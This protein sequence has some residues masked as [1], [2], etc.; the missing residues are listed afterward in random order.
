MTLRTLL[1][2]AL[3][4]AMPCSL[5]ADP[6]P[7]DE[8]VLSWDDG[9]P[10]THIA[11]ETDDRAAVGFQAPSVSSRLVG[12]QFYACDDGA[13]NPIHPMLPTTAPFLFQVWRVYSSSQVRPGDLV[14]PGYV[15]FPDWYSYPEDQWLDIVLPNPIDVGDTET[16]PEGWFFIGLKWM[17][18]GNPWLGVD[19]DLPHHDVGWKHEVL[20]WIPVEEG[21][22]LLRAVVQDSSGTAVLE[23]SWGS[24]KAGYR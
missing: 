8:L 7:R 18:D 9:E 15:P 14:Y 6:S 19:S 20:S 2:V 22:V 4:C 17:H 24:L 13:V 21:D 16:F 10:E 23:A 5:L 12:F 3:A 11:L 1:A